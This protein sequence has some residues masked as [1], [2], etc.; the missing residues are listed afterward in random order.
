MNAKYVQGDSAENGEKGPNGVHLGDQAFL[1]LTDVQNDEV[2][3][4]DG[5]SPC[6]HL[7]ENSPFSSV[8]LHV[9]IVSGGIRRAQVAS[10][11]I[12]I[13]FDS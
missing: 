11:W 12:V 5:F 7:A 3:N 13:L 1:D 6:Q 8:H 2:S 4:R 10:C 9:L